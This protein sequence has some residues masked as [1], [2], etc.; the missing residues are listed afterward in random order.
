[1]KVKVTLAGTGR[2]GKTCF[3]ETLQN[4]ADTRG[5]YQRTVRFTYAA[6]HKPPL[7]D[8]QPVIVALWDAGGQRRLWPL[9]KSYVHNSS[10]VLF[11]LCG[12]RPNDDTE[13]YE[14]HDYLVTEKQLPPD[15]LKAVVCG[16]ADIGIDPGLHDRVSN[17]ASQ[18]GYPYFEIDCRSYDQVHTVLE[19]LLSKLLRTSA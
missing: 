11:F 13:L 4:G 2:S 9:L 5:P 3:Q 10:I 7:V 1:M 19:E 8:C 12:T 6:P 15:G 17:W 18:H 14:L 16:F